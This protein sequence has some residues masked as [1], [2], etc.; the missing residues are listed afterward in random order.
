LESVAVDG[1]DE[2]LEVFLPSS[3]ARQQQPT[4]L[5]GTVQLRSTD[6]PG[7]WLA[8]VQASQLTVR[9]NQTLAVAD[10]PLVSLS[11]S[12]SDLLLLVWQRLSA[13]ASGIA[14]GGDTSLLA[15]FAALTDL[16]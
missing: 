9:R 16:R 3:L 7:T 1:V 15:R 10:A 12:A 5:G 11:A 4:D 6:R 8:T 2:F 14:V 13:S